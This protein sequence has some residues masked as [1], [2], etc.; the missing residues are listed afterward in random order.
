M[1]SWFL[2]KYSV[3]PGIKFVVQH[4]LKTYSLCVAPGA[5]TGET[6]NFHMNKR[7]VVGDTASPSAKMNQFMI[8]E[9]PVK[10][11]SE[12]QKWKKQNK[13]KHTDK[14]KQETVTLQNKSREFFLSTKQELVL[15]YCL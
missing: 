3:N 10:G 15:Q 7:V 4:N 1:A 14:P 11:E 2:V 8:S 12:I 5:T 9:T 6:H 13:T